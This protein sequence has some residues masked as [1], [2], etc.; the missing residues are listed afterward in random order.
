M[1]VIA[2]TGAIIAIYDSRDANHRR[3]RDAI[4]R[5]TGVIVVSAAAELRFLE[6]FTVG[7]FALEPFTMADLE[8]CR[9]LLSSPIANS[10][11]VCAM[12]L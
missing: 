9:G 5:E 4:E 8:H 10:I 7:A 2:D 3:V 1:A 11:W 12:P 6:A